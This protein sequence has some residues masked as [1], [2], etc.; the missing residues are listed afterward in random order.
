[1]MRAPARIYRLYRRFCA[2]TRGVAAIELGM[3]LPV[4]AILFLGSFDGGRAIAI[5]M[6][7]RSATY[8]L[9]AIAN[10]YETIQASDM[11]SITGAT[12][13]VLAPYSSSPVVV[14]ISQIA[15]SSKGVTTVA[16]SYS[17]GG[18]ARTQGA[19]IT[20]PSNIKTLAT[21]SGSGTF[22]YLIFAEVSYT[23]TPMFGYFTS[24]SI[25]FSDNLYV[26]PRSSSCIAYVPLEIGSLT[27]P[28]ACT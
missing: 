15:I 18:T 17:Q 7:V 9:G 3:I 2:L 27:I 22:N 11:T 25:N 13:V 26:T 16:W 24:G 23:F 14:T 5:Y 12:S 4:L 19:S 10:Q 28:L 8:T 20:I 21:P 6:K 1:M